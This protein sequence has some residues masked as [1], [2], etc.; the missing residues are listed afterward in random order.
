MSATQSVDMST[1]PLMLRRPVSVLEPAG[2]GGVG[3][4]SG[5]GVLAESKTAGMPPAVRAKSGANGAELRLRPEEE[6][7]LR[8][9]L[10][11]LTEREREVVLA[12]CEGGTNE[13]IAD[14]LCIALPT[15]RTHLMRLNQ[16]LGTTSKGDV[17]RHAAGILI[18]GYRCGAI[19]PEPTQAQSQV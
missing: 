11:E 9:N 19:R 6:H 4:P 7:F 3:S 2:K 13:A 14:R 16:K 12:I 17:V 8:M 1:Q 15:L 10:T 5:L 18:E